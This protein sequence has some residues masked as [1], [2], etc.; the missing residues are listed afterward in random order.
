[1]KEN[2]A[3]IYKQHLD[4]IFKSY[5]N[6]IRIY[7]ASKKNIKWERKIMNNVDESGTSFHKWLNMTCTFLYYLI[8]PNGH[9]TG[10]F[11]LAIMH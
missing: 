5:K 9:C 2:F 8:G 4:M 1:M 6:S 11:Q 10:L 7:H 3:A